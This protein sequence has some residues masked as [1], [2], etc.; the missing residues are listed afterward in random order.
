MGG[1]VNN[2][3]RFF[4]TIRPLLL[5]ISRICEQH[6]ILFYASFALG[7]DDRG[8]KFQ[9]FSIGAT[10]DDMEFKQAVEQTNGV[11]L[12][13]FRRWQ[14]AQASVPTPATPAPDSTE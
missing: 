11:L 4:K 13:S 10:P 9:T 8:T 12:R 1:S 6:G 3:Q 2:E 5:R 14:E 7:P